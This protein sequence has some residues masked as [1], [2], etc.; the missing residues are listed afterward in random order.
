M[1]LRLITGPAGSGKSFRLMQRI[2][3]ESVAHPERNYLLI[4]PEQYSLHTQSE[5]IRLHPRHGLLNIDVLSL[6]KLALRTFAETGF[7]TS[8]L[9][10]ESGKSIV[11][12]R[13]ALSIKDALPYLGTRLSRPGQIT[14]VKSL[15]SELMQ[16]A[17]SPD[18]LSMTADAL[19][20]GLS[21]KITDIAAL[22]REYE[23]FC[24]Q[25]Y[26]N[27]EEMPL[28]LA[29]M[30]PYAP[31]LKNTTAAFDG[32][33]GF[34]PVQLP[35][36]R[37]LMSNCRD[38]YVTAALDWADSSGLFSMSRTMIASLKKIAAETGTPVL[39][40]ETVLRDAPGRHAGNESLSFLER[41]LF[42]GKRAV[43]SGTPDSIRM[44]VYASPETEVRAA[45]RKIR[46][47][48][49]TEGL[50]CR[51]FAVITGDLA[52]YGDLVRR[53][54][55]SLDIPFFVDEKRTILHHP[56]TEFLRAAMQTAVSGWT[57]AALVRLLR[58][59]LL[60][61]SADETDR[62]ENYAI[63]LGLKRRQQYEEPFTM[64]YY[65]Q[66][67]A[68]L[69]LLNDV[70]ERILSILLPFSSLFQKRGGNAREKTEA[71]Y[72]LSVSCGI[73]QKLMDESERF[74]K[75]GDA[76]LSREYRQIYGLVIQLFDKIVNVLGGH[77]VSAADYTAMFETA[78]TESRIGII[79]P[80]G[81]EVMICDAQRSRIGDIRVLFF[82]GM[83]EGV[84]PQNTEKTGLLT[85]TDRTLLTQCGITLSPDAKEEAANQLFYLY[86]SLTKPR[87]MLYLSCASMSAGSEILHPSPVLG[88]ISGLFPALAPVPEDGTAFDSAQ[89]AE[90]AL[91]SLP[92]ALHDQPDTTSSL[93]A[94]AAYL[95]L[96]I[97]AP[98]DPRPK[99]LLR[100]ASS[101][102]P[103][104]SLTDAV[105]AVLY[106]TH[107]S[108]SA[109]RLEKYAS[110][111]F[112]HFAQ[113]GL[114]L[115]ERAEYT[116]SGID[117]GNV[118]HEALASFA[119]KVTSEGRRIQDLDV[120]ERDALCRRCV[121]EAVSMYGNLLFFD[122]ARL[123][124]ETDRLIRLMKR[125]VWALARQLS[126]GDFS[127]SGFEV[128][129][130]KADGLQSQY[131]RLG[132]NA[133]LSLTGRID[134]IDLC[135]DG[136]AVYVNIYD[137][138]TG[139]SSFSLSELYAGTQ[140]QLPLYLSAALTIAEKQTGLIPVPSGLFYY[141]VTDPVIL[142]TDIKEGYSAEDSL[143]LVH[144]PSGI[145]TDDP[146]I[147]GHIDRGLGRDYSESPVIPL[148]LKKDR[149]PTARSKTAS[150]E[151][152]HTMTRYAAHLAARFGR[153]I[154]SGSVA[155][156]PIRTGTKS[157]CD[158]CPYKDICG[159]RREDSSHFRTL[160]KEDREALFA[161]MKEEI[162]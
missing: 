86:L 116:Y 114:R 29:R 83:N 31:S 91:S 72:R 127:P 122:S 111:A 133:D 141:P 45:A 34:T 84:I 134:R 108:G 81:D 97:A 10:E 44:S 36:V 22:F 155:A 15:I 3:G 20:P 136:P 104:D 77:P 120:P 151:D 52:R 138:K 157:A 64:C 161:K 129:F 30:I 67:P 140:L 33:T 132:G 63:A 7:R 126:A 19:P 48:M 57:A 118:L 39:P 156:E 61:V 137:Y 113:Y 69:V 102:R 68:E 5:L 65:G 139:P 144:R 21:G 115:R 49:R 16:Y 43:Y 135:K 148:G 47:L 23:S 38:V 27:A 78:L 121:E 79:P 12:R 35:A 1:A 128:S 149:K 142:E 42:R 162:E 32:F 130:Q 11:L 98:D 24:E 70:R 145:V 153:E 99:D 88:M 107:L 71:L 66:D 46:A 146:A 53:I 58:T 8:E 110:C 131:F 154:L 60:P 51:D 74:R 28:H 158:Y 147:I 37:A 159:F 41:H 76:A 82:L 80:S 112:A 124:Y 55:P 93:K 152:F 2:I 90:D 94:A 54:F 101:A 85:E 6:H 160:E 59:G 103:H 50:R 75:A 125:T 143:L 25:N 26:M 87:D 89:T 96:R 117:R 105:A 150:S 109:S 14:E 18:M 56:Y 17:V 40:E 62:L 73:Q 100:A 4:V 119:E 92:Y 13:I 106:G 9:L 95:A 123:V